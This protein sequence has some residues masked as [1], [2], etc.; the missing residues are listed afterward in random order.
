MKLKISFELELE[1]E[2]FSKEKFLDDIEQ[3]VIKFSEITH[4]D[5][6][7]VIIKE[8]QKMKNLQVYVSSKA[9]NY[10]GD[11]WEIL[12]KV[13]DI[14][15]KGVQFSDE[16]LFFTNS[17]LSRMKCLKRKHMMKVKQYNI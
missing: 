6:K 11:G 5:I 8:K 1:N 7:K 2:D 10:D 15:D 17:R 14:T 9:R 16:Y 4:G 3:A 12:V 13:K